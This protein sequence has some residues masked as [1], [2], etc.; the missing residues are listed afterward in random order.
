MTYGLGLVRV[1][2][3]LAVRLLHVHAE[4][5]LLVTAHVGVAHEVQRVVVDAHHRRD[6][7]QLDL[8]RID[9]RKTIIGT[10]TAQTGGI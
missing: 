8:E 3:S 1:A 7:V 4:L 9:G 5:I 10:V 2:V 6:K